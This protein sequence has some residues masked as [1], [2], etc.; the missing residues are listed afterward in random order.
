[1]IR[2]QEILEQQQDFGLKHVN[3]EMFITH[4]NNLLDSKLYLSFIESSL[5]LRYKFGSH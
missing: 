3:Y 5:T 2:W 1:M 4:R